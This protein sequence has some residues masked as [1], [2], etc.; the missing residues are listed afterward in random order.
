[1]NSSSINLFKKTTGCPSSHMLLLYCSSELSTEIMTRV[2]LHLGSCDFCSSEIPLLAYHTPPCSG[3][4]KPPEIPINLRLLAEALLVR[5][6]RMREER[7][8]SVFKQGRIRFA[9]ILSGQFA[10]ER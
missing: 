9:E 10:G 3:E 8:K 5:V 2:R 4:C 1:M 7:D 6:A